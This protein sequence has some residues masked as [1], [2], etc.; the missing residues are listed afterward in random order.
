MDAAKLNFP[1]NSFDA[2]FDFGIIHHIPN[3][4]DCISE[5]KRVLNCN[6]EVI[7][8]ELSTD[9]FT[10]VSGRVWKALLD[11]PYDRMFSTTEFANALIAAGF[12]LQGF[13]ESYPFRILK[14]FS[15]VARKLN[16]T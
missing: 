7:I 16:S 11:H 14:H 1:D 2:V 5:M 9:T 10:T 3:W 8:E 15:L 12:E 4:N 6:G 13:C